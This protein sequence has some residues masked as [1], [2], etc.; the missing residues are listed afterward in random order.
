TVSGV[1][2]SDW[3]VV[4]QDQ[5]ICAVRG[6][7]VIILCSFYYPEEETVQS[8]K[9][10][11]ERNDVFDGPFIYDSVIKNNTNTSSRFHYIGDKKHNCS[12]QILH[13]TH[14]DTG[15]Y[16]FR[17]ITNSRKGRFTG[18]EGSTLQV[19]DLEILMSNENQ[20]FKEGDS[21]NLTCVSCDSGLPSEL[22][23][24][25]NG[26][27]IHEGRVLYLGNI[28]SMSSGDYVCSLRDTQGQPQEP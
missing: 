27:A 10:G 15:K 28:S 3:H 18:A 9:W 23:W 4:Y 7:S 22:I 19:V 21:V 25:K 6:S 20:T 8:V 17:F 1:L 11:H 13:V 16:V 24:L 2:S 5:N 12:F 14:N 26:R